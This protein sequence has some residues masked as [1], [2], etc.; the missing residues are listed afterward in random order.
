MNLPPKSLRAQ[1]KIQNATK[2][3]YI[4]I[5]I[6]QTIYELI[7][8]W[9]AA[10]YFRVTNIL[11]VQ[12]L[13][14]G[15]MSSLTSAPICT[16]VIRVCTFVGIRRESISQHLVPVMLETTWLVMNSFSC[17][18][19]ANQRGVEAVAI[20]LVI[21]EVLLCNMWIGSD[22]SIIDTFNVADLE[23]YLHPIVSTC[24]HDTRSRITWHCT[25]Y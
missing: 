13:H 3:L 16:L 15:L 19:W 25:K 12:V 7:H 10:D 1:T 9:W 20:L 18:F 2:L 14:D 11:G 22:S 23:E 8:K 5:H 4:V 21:A 6:I 24:T 17:S